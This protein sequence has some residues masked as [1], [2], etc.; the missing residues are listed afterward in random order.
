MVLVIDIVIVIVLVRVRVNVIVRDAKVL[1][2]ST[3]LFYGLNLGNEDNWHL[4]EVSFFSQHLLRAEIELLHSCAK[5]FD[6]VI[7]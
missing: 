7:S 5:G 6:H 3:F 4:T 2:I 1:V